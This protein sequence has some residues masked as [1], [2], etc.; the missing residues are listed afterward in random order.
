MALQC[1]F[2]FQHLFREHRAATVTRLALTVEDSRAREVP[3]NAMHSAQRLRTMT[4]FMLE[5]D[6]IAAR[7][8]SYYLYKGPAYYNIQSPD[9]PAT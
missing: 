4:E 1:A 7:A 6:V 9:S 3:W 5:L 8:Y 2:L